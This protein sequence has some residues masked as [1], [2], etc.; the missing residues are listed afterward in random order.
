MYPYAVSKEGLGA[1]AV[2]LVA[3]VQHLYSLST[4]ETFST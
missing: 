2:G 1:R 3:V 4:R